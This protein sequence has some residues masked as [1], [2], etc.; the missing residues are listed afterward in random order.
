MSATARIWL[1]L[2][3]L[4]VA[5]FSWYT[6]FGGPLDPGEIAAYLELLAE[7][8]DDPKALGAH[9]WHF[10]NSL[11][12][13]LDEERYYKVGTKKPNPWGLYDMHGNVA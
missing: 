3:F 12:E 8:S 2:A 1:V 6:S 4:Y 11:D 9:A 7:R 5:F 13:K 10:H